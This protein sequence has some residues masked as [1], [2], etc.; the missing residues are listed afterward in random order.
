MTSAS[1]QALI[2]ERDQLLASIAL[3][4]EP[5]FSAFGDALSESALSRLQEILG[6]PLDR[7]NA[8]V[9]P[10][11]AEPIF[12]LL[13]RTETGQALCLQA[14]LELIREV[15]Q[16]GQDTFRRTPGGWMD[17]AFP[18]RVNGLVAQCI[19]CRGFLDRPFFPEEIEQLAAVANADAAELEAAVEKTRRLSASQQEAMLDLVRQIR[20]AMQALA[21]EFVRAAEISHQF[22]QSERTRALGTLSSG[23]AHHFNNLLSVILGYSSY[24]ANQEDLSSKALEAL[25]NITGAA[26]RGRRLTEEILAFAGSEVEEEATCHLH[27][28]VV[29]VLSLLQSQFSS[30][31]QVETK[32]AATTDTVRAPPSSV[33]QLVFNLLTNAFDSIPVGGRVEV[34]TENGIR[35]DSGN[36]VEQIRLTIT[37][38][39][40]ILPGAESDQGT[41]AHH[42]TLKLSR[43]QGIAGSLQGSV[44]VTS[45]PGETTRVEVLL[46]SGTA[47]QMQPP[48]RR[49]TRRI[50]PSSIWVVDD[51][52]IFREMCRQTM[53]SEGHTVEEMESGPEMQ[54]RWQG[55]PSKPDLLIIDFS[56]PESN[57]LELC[58]WLKE[59]G[60]RTPVVLVSG[61][62]ANHPDIRQALEM[63][64]TYFLQKP[65]SFRELMDNVVV[66]MGE[67]LIE[68]SGEWS[69]D[70]DEAPTPDRP[71]G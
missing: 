24:V 3:P 4:A 70:D 15:I 57:G 64:K 53:G 50:T 60:S 17:A 6:S 16:S 40:G 55:T 46:P 35:R 37:D 27:G 28:I 25:N 11:A 30:K 18:V 49:T 66:A 34:M 20:D 62:A 36:T 52:A 41:G 47:R 69:V 39:S 43:A 44:S 21:I 65:F 23:V 32:L 48:P 8:G 51:D 26:Q 45:E 13:H 19:W 2:D 58:Q 71:R 63:R 54:S 7:W 12:R 68:Q 61:F 42:R 1:I 38:S 9:A 67:T 29:S 14:D 59:Q 10:V 22:V 33:H 5:D 31:V 56:M